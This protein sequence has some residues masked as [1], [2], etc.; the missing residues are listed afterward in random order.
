MKFQYSHSFL[1]ANRRNLLSWTLLALLLPAATAAQAQTTNG[2]VIYC[3]DYG[4]FLAH[5]ATTGAVNTAGVST[6]DPATCLWTV[7]S[8]YIRP[9][10]DDGTTVLGGLYLTHTSNTLGT[11]TATTNATWTNAIANGQP[12]YSSG[13]T[14]R[15][16]VTNSTTWQIS[17]TNSRRATIYAVT[18]SSTTGEAVA[19]TYHGTLSGTTDFYSVGATYTYVP[20]VTHTAAY[21]KTNTTYTAATIGSLGT[22]VTDN[23]PAPTAVSLGSGWTVVWSLSDDTYAS[24]NAATGELTVNTL[25]ATYATNTVT[26]TATHTAS[27]SVVVASLP[28]TIYASEEVMKQ[29]ILDDREDHTWKY[30]NDNK[31]DSDYPDRLRSPNPRNVKITYKGGSVSGATEVAVSATEPQN[32]FVYYKTIERLAWGDGT[33]HFLTGEYAYRVIPNPF[34]KRPRTNGATGTNGFYGFGG[35]KIVSGGDHIDGHDDGDVLEL[36]EVINFTGLNTNYT[37]NCTSAEVVLEATWVEAS[38][39]TATGD[40]TSSPTALSN[41]GTYETN[42]IVFT[43]GGNKTV[44]GQTKAVTVSNQYPD[45]TPAGSSTVNNFTTSSADVKLEYVKIG[46]GETPVHPLTP[47]TMSSTGIGSGTFTAGSGC[48]LIVGRGCTG[49]VNYLCGNANGGKTIR[50]E[51]GK[52]QYMYPMAGGSANASNWCRLVLGCDFDRAAPDAA[53]GELGNGTGDNTKLRVVN[54][55]SLTGGGSAAGNGTSE[56]MDITIKSGYYGFSANRNIGGAEGD[57]DGY[58]LGIGGNTDKYNVTFPGGQYTTLSADNT[59]NNTYVISATTTNNN[60]WRNTMSFYVGPTRSAGKGGVNR[61]LIEGG[62]LSSVNGGGTEPGSEDAIGFHFRMKGGWV[63]GAVYGTA[64]ISNSNGSRRLVFTGGEVNGWVAGGCN[65]TDFGNE[66][67][68]YLGVNRGTCYIYAGG[69]TE[70]RSHDRLGHYNNA[71]GL[72]YNVPGGQIFG[73]GRGLYPVDGDDPTYCGST[74]TAY[75]VVADD[76]EVEQNVYGGG[77]NGVSQYSHVYILGGTVGKKVFGGTAKAISTD[78]TWRCRTTDVRMYGGTVKGG[79]YGGHDE[80]GI[81]YSNADVQI[82]GGT[83]GAEDQK[84]GDGSRNHDLGNVF[85]GG[86]GEATSIQGNVVVIVGDSTARTPHVDSPLIWGNVF[87]GGHE[88]NYTSNGKTFKVLGYNGT[89]KESVFG[90]GKGSGHNDGK[91]TGDTHV[92]L[93]GSIEVGNVFGGGMAGEVDGSTYVKISD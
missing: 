86:Y 18:S 26:Y 66:G 45:G 50:L 51:S 11:S 64:S 71:Y 89:V 17:T 92:W 48:S 36:E 75:V 1:R 2:Y 79:V 60:Q 19:A 6:F 44:S 38:V 88:A 12:Q 39:V 22:I 42:F 72:V 32:T 65:G 20:T 57:A 27:G 13:G 78:G 3:N 47:T 69:R 56:L 34:S 24:I 73:A 77:Y 90:G 83:V 87:G 33:G 61:L 15:L 31:P 62:E 4:L 82:L 14:Q 80:T 43:N 23:P 53:D 84:L 35:W 28:V 76:A 16:R 9:T 52:Y 81:Q 70:F 40:V 59:T 5:D 25:P 93:K 67:N 30:Y 58:G 46:D 63:K 91:I 29:V 41:S 10:S 55:V 7:G 37:S 68:N 54:Y 85:G 49:T 8:N 21:N 74:T